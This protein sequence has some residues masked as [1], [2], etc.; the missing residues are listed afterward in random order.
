MGHKDTVLIIEDEANIGSLIETILVHDDYKTVR[1]MSAGAGLSLCTSCCPDVV[2]LD[3]GLPDLDGME[4]LRRIREFSSVP[5]IVVSA[6]ME[7]QEKVQALDAGADDY[8]TKP[9][10]ADELLARIRTAL[11]HSS[12]GA[13]AD[14]T[15]VYEREGLMIDFG[16]R[17]VT[18]DGEQIRLT[19]VEYKI[20]SL[21]AAQAGRVLTYTYLLEQIWGP[22][23][24][25]NNQILRVN[26]A[27]IRRKLKEN[28]ADPR[29]IMT[30]VGVGY[31]M[32]E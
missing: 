23:T 8:I 29:Y 28:P 10:G 9:F 13:M 7:E 20:V 22:Y 2:L 12:A 30:E 24:D 21:L 31:R 16:R 4:V 3:L 26:M 25:D 5:V 14:Q 11:R 19:P 1:A 17:L 6:R 18:L 27:N 32:W 15:P